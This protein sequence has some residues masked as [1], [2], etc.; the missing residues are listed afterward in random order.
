M[1]NVA[2]GHAADLSIDAFIAK[3]HD[4]RVK[5]EG[6][7]E[8]EALWQASVRA[9]NAR[10]GEEQRLERLAWHEGQAA[11]LSSTLGALVAYHKDQAERYRNGHHEEQSA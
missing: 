2:P 9:Y 3:R 10:C 5:S 4:Q 7:R 8:R 6:E 11:R 1:D